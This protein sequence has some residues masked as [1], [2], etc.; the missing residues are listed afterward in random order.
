[1]LKEGKDFYRD[2]DGLMVL[3]ESYLKSRGYCC[4]S[5]CKHCPYG[6]SEEFDPNIPVELQLGFHEESYE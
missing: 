3:T 6:Y 5:A 1:M 4:K 2:E